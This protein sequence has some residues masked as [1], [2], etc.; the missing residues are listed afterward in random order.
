M[1]KFKKCIWITNTVAA[2]GETGITL[3]EL[4]H[5]GHKIQ[6]TIPSQTALFSA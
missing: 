2:A 5:S 1:D 3:A 4:N 6:I